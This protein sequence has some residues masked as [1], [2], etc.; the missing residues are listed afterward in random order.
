MALMGQVSSPFTYT[1]KKKSKVLYVN[2]DRFV[3]LLGPLRI[4]IT[5]SPKLY[6]EFD[7]RYRGSQNRAA[8]KVKTTTSTK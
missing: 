8:A 4:L 6:A 2:R 5:R 7:R 1:V 3:K